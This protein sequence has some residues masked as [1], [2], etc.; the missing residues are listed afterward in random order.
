LHCSNRFTHEFP[1][2]DAGGNFYQIKDPIAQNLH[3]YWDIGLGL[4]LSP[5][6]NRQIKQLAAHL[7]QTYP[8]HFFTNAQLQ[9]NP[10]QWVQDSFNISK[11]FVYQVPENGTPSA[12]YV[13]QGQ[14]IVSQQLVLAGYRLADLLNNLQGVAQ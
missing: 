3:A 8:R 10:T 4:L 11:N 6:S 1:Q 5:L 12:D 2:G 13:W 7:Q 9:E 14:K